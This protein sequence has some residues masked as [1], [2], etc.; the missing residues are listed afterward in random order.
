MTDGQSVSL[1]WYQGTIWKPR[2]SF[3]FLHGYYIQK[4]AVF[5]VLDVLSD[6]RTDL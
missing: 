4:F 5:L 1:P 2:P 3:L 6:E